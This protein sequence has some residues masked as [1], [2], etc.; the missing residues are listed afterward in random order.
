MSILADESPASSRAVLGPGND[1]IHVEKFDLGQWRRARVRSI[2]RTPEYKGLP[3]AC[4]KLVDYLVMHHDNPTGGMFPNQGL[5]SEKKPGLAKRFGVSRQTINGYLK[6]I[7]DAKVFCEPEHRFARAGEKRGKGGR[8]S[9]IYRVNEALFLP[10]GTT[11]LDTTPDSSPDSGSTSHE[12]HVEA[13][14]RECNGSRSN[15]AI[16]SFL[17]ALS[18]EGEEDDR[19]GLTAPA[20]S[21]YI[22]PSRLSTSTSSCRWCGNERDVLEASGYCSQLCEREHARFVRIA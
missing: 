12:V 16:V 4:R 10:S 14:S 2:K 5:G 11:A 13:L 1:L 20:S 21:T 18:R 7:V 22:R 17:V 15:D 19:A 9:N 8:M 3:K 6:M